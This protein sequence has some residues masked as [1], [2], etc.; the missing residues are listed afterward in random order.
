MQ[1]RTVQGF[2]TVRRHLRTMRTLPISL[3]ILAT[4]AATAPQCTV[5]PNTDFWGNDLLDS[6]TGKPS[7]Q[8]CP[9]GPSDC[10]AMCSDKK[11]DSE[12]KGSCG[13]WSWNFQSKTCWMKTEAGRDPRNSTDTSGV[14]VSHKPARPS[15]KGMNILFVVSDDLG[16][17]DVS[18]HGSPQIPTPNLDYLA[19]TGVVLDSHHAQPVC[20]PTRT[21]IMSG[22]HVIH[23]GI[24]MPFEQGT[25]YHLDLNYTLLPGYMKK[26]G[27]DTAM[28]GKWHC[29]QNT[30]SAL[31][32]G[33]GFDSYFGYWSGA[34]D[35]YTHECRGAY[36]LADG[37][38]T[39]F[40]FNGTYSTPL[41]TAK[42]VDFIRKRAADTS[43]TAS[44]NGNGQANYDKP[45]KPWFMYLAYQNVH[46]PLEAPQSYLDQFANTT[47]GSK[48]RQA[49]CAMAKIMDD[50]IGNLTTA[51]RETNQ[52]DSTLIVFTADSP[53][54]L[55]E[56]TWSSN[57]PMRGGKN[58]IWGGGHRVAALVRGGPGVLAPSLVGGTLNQHIHV[59]DWVRSLVHFAADDAAAFE[60]LVPPSEPPYLDGDGIDVWPQ[61]A[62][63]RQVR[64]EVLHEAHPEGAKDT[65]H[66]D[67]LTS[68][69]WKILRLGST[70]PE[71]ETGWHVPPGLDASK[72]TFTLGCD[73]SKQPAAVDQSEC[74]TQYCLFNVKDDPC[75]YTNVADNHPDIIKRLVARLQQLKAAAVLPLEPQGCTPVITRG[76]WRPCDSPNPD[77]TSEN[78]LAAAA[79]AAHAPE[80]GA[81]FSDDDDASSF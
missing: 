73:L 57:Y 30:L 79:A 80:A 45:Q 9:G 67:G 66:G 46:W 27:Y 74:T 17:N 48:Q 76:A 72:V 32:T 18:F 29:G 4:A 16:W 77:G 68:G 15:T 8:P 11:E 21:S 10:C 54:N 69:D 25:A 44:D 59:S 22:R 7:P 75:E 36:D 37:I 39:A 51:L 62:E 50:G 14:V 12:P 2:G 20:S 61:L 55:N 31:P 78:T 71:M 3:L 38:R 41:W 33:R 19:S 42:A 81:V 13:A 64:T 6:T 52:L 49:V 60:T 70:H 28:I 26:L 34:E 40:E 63:A 65:V 23:T 47:G 5:T 1:F 24:Y 35:Y 56:G 53:T 58:T 43:A